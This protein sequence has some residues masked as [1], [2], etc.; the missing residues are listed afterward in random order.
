MAPP[1]TIYGIGFAG[2][3]QRVFQT[4]GVFL[5]VFKLEGINWQRFLAD[6]IAPAFHPA[7]N[8]GA[9][10]ARI[11]IVMCFRTS[12]QTCEIGSSRSVR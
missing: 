8:R 7:A 5:A 4:V 1:M 12:G 10:R 9:A 3:F 2:G 11:R 6:F